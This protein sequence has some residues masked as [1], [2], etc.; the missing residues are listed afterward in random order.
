[1]KI[2]SEQKT[3]FDIKTLFRQSNFDNILKCVHCG[4]C[5]DYCPTYRE[6]D[7][8]KDSPRCRLFL[9]R[10][11]WEGKLE[12]ENSVIEPLSRCLDCRACESACPSGVPY[13]ELL[14]KTR[15]IIL[16]NKNQTFK[17]RILRKIFLKS[18]FCS[19]NLLIFLSRLIKIY[20]V[21]G[22]PKI[23]T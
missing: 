1:M 12:L 19:T 2:I 18:I 9:M 8:E 16:E 6:L 21:S 4:L 15:G 10:G 14:E 17:E 13:A 11:L 7:D 23:I 3:S 22:I 20:I 5:L